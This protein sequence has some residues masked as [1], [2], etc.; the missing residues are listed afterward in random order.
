MVE[1]REITKN[2]IEQV[3]SLEVYDQ[4]RD[5]V[6][7]IAHSLAQAWVYNDTAF[8]YAIYSDNIPVGFVMLG[9]YAIKDQYTLW[10]FLIDKRHQGKGYG[11]KAL[12]L[13]IDLLVK[14]YHVNE[15]YTGVAFGNHIA[16]QL[17]ESV[18]F[19]ETGEKDDFQ[20]EMKLAISD[21][22]K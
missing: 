4:Q 16:K 13:A 1:L 18:G 2:N 7:T 11:R 22:A 9:Y 20:L 3:L 8:P 17:Y 5:Y 6:S 21:S 12:M 14:K 15:I 10:K 19:K